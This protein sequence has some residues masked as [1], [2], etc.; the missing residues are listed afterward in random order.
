M[1]PSVIVGDL[2]Y[3]DTDQEEVL[4]AL[5]CAD[6]L[7]RGDE[8]TPEQARAW[9]PERGGDRPRVSLCARAGKTGKDPGAVLHQAGTAGTGR[10]RIRV[11]LEVLRQAGLLALEESGDSLH[12][13]VLPA[14]ERRI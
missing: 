3:A 2:R 13:R 1:T 12:I 11:A 4:A 5:R 8:L 6:S 14:Q 7:S 10:P 9:L